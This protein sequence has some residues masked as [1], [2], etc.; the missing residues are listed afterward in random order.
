MHPSSILDESDS[1]FVADASVIISITACEYATQIVSA[2]PNRII[3]SDMVVSELESGRGKGYTN[4]EQLRQL[5][6]DGLIEVVTMGVVATDHFEELTIGLAK[7]TLDDGEAATIACAMEIDGVPLL[8]ERKARRI[9]E[10]KYPNLSYG[11]SVD[12]FAHRGVGKVLGKTDLAL[13]VLNALEQSRMRVLPEYLD[14]VVNLIGHENAA[15][16]KSLPSSVRQ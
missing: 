11:C 9:C 16:C 3:V 4:A 13:A 7:N 8:D 10:E 12:I 2:V 6:R 1:I 14:W 15:K 5:I